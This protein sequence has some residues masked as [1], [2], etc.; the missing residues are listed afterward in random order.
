[1]KIIF[2]IPDMSWLYDY[3]AQFPLGILYLSTALRQMEWNVE[4]F[5]TNI[6]SIY[7]I[8]EADVYAF[9]VVYNTYQDS[10]RLAQQLRKCRP[11]SLLIVGGVAPTVE[12]IGFGDFFDCLFIGESEDSIKLFCKDYKRKDVKIAYKQSQQTDISYLLPDRSIL[13]DDYVRTGSIFTGDEIYC[14][15]GS[16]SIMFSRGCPFSCIFCCSPKLYGKKIRFRNVQSIVDEI[17]SI[18]DV[19]GIRQFRIQDDTFT[20]K[21][22]FLKQLTKELK[23]LNIYYRCSTRV[24]VISDEVVQMLY[25]S[26]CR[27]IGIGVEAADDK[28][29]HLLKK[30]ITVEQISKAIKIIRKYPIKVRCFFMMGYPFDTE[31]LMYKNIRFIEDNRLDNVVTCNL[32]PFPGTELYENRSDFGI[33]SIKRDACMNFASHIKL[34]PNFLCDAMS[35]DEHI[36]IMKIFYDYMIGKDFI[37]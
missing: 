11:N 1:M 6:K 17:Q 37:R 16:T 31:D 34:A 35:E 36:R 13:P 19:Y 25:D 2:V 28:I 30:N 20:I 9:S 8:P 3:K 4:I 18:I 14:K 21:L 32:I 23:K 22:S 10:V 24:D 27:E 12:A 5:D 33:T 7:L 29:L 15:G 26:G